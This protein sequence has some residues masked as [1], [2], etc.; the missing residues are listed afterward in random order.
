M[1]KPNAKS[2]LGAIPTGSGV[3]FR[4][5]SIN[6]EKVELCLFDAPGDATPARRVQLRRAATRDVWQ[7][8]VPGVGPGQLYGYR[9]TGPHEPQNGHRFNASKLLVD[10]WARAITGEPRPDPALYGFVAVGWPSELWRRHSSDLTFSGH[11]SAAAAPKCVVVDPELDWRGD[12]PPGTSWGDTVIYEC[13]VKGMTQRHP[14]IEER[15]RGTYLGLAQPPVIEHLQS[16]GVT[17]VELLPVHQIARESHLMIRG[18]PNYWGYSTLGYFA[19]HAGYATGGLGEQVAEFKQMV[20]ELHRAGI[21]VILDVVYNHTAEGSRMGPTLSLRGIDNRSYYRLPRRQ[22]GRYVDVTGCGNSLDLAHDPVREMVLASLRYWVD[23]MHVDGFRFDLASALARDGWNGDFDSNSVFFRE[24]A[25]D[26]VL[27]R[28]KL[29]AEPWDVGHG[30]YQLGRFPPEWS[31]WNDRYRDGLRRF[32]RGDGDGGELALRVAGS[33]DLFAGSPRRSVNFVT[34]HDG[35]TLRDLVSHERRHNEANREA[36]R[37]GN[38]HNLSRNW[39]HEGPILD[40]EIIADRDRARRNFVATLLLSRGVP[41]LL[42]GDELGRTQGGNNNAYCQDNEASWVD[43]SL[44]DE[45]FLDFVRRLVALRREH[46]ALRAEDTSGES[47]VWPAEG[48][49]RRAVAMLIPA[50]EDGDELVLLANGSEAEVA[51]ELPEASVGWVELLDT[52]RGMISDGEPVEGDAVPVA[53]F[54]LRLL[55]SLRANGR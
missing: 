23:E 19:P 39:G 51:F 35:F 25:A 12:R 32:W 8:T 28:V 13:H 50:P 18:Q 2:Q 14:E 7:T 55:R 45:D 16:L 46:P 53:A 52:A 22:P 43:W 49:E 17:A 6:A 37:D 42:G 3:R 31:E 21:E 36:N 29:V 1:P 20:R 26:P 11:D 47:R 48:S 15:L 27:S 30:G 44:V 4:L 41:M 38:D 10:P 34:S 40:P 33:P 54:S 9:V 24:I 5:F